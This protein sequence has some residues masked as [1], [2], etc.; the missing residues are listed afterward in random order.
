MSHGRVRAFVG[1]GGNSDGA[2]Q[3]VARFDA[4]CAAIARLTGVS[5]VRRASLYTTRPLGPVPDQPAFVNSAALVVLRGWHPVDFLAELLAIEAQLGRDRT[6][7]QRQGPRPIDLD[8]LLWD[9]FVTDSPGPPALILPHPRLAGRAFALAPLAELS[10]EDQLIPGPS[11][12]RVGERLAAALADPG[13]RV[14]R[15]AE[16]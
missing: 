7:E 15:L 5:S 8:L 14:E 16:P 2:A 3:V 12:G 13:Q 9:D 10:G 1:L 6:R 4:A 11:G